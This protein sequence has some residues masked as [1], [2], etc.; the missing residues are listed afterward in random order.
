MGKLHGGM[1]SP[2]I[3]PRAC[4]ACQPLKQHMDPVSFIIRGPGAGS[5]CR[6]QVGAQSVACTALAWSLGLAVAPS[7]YQ[8]LQQPALKPRGA[9]GIGA[10]HGYACEYQVPARRSEF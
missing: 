8:P 6:H 1:L 3:S 4:S 10:S 9:M 5:L 7:A 2:N